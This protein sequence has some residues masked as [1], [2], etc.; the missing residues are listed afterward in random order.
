M[1]VKALT[2]FEKLLSVVGLSR[3]RWKTK[4]KKNNFALS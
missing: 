3:K 2:E 1:Y 4:A